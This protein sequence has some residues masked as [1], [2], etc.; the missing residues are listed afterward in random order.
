MNSERA[1]ILAPA[2][3]DGAVAASIMQQAGK[4]AVCCAD[5]ASLINELEVGAG[6]AIIVIEALEYTDQKPLTD[7]IAR[8][9]PWSDFPFIIL[10]HRV[11]TPD[12]TPMLTRLQA[13]VGNVIFL[14][15]PF[16]PT[17]LSNVVENALRGRRRQYEARD[18]LEDR[19]RLLTQLAEEKA[20]TQAALRGEQALSGLLITSVPAGIVAY[21][22]NLAVT[23]WN[24]VM[25][26]LLKLPAAEATGKPLP[27]LV[28]DGQASAIATGLKEALAGTPGPIEE[29]ELVTDRAG[30]LVLETQ[31][32]PLRGGDGEIVGGAAFF[33]D[34]TER[35]RIEEQLR[36]A[37][38]MET[39]GQLTGGVAHDFNNLLSAIQGNLELLRKR[40][41]DDAH[42][43]RYIDGALQGASRGASLTARLLA[44][45][46][47]QELQ[48]RPTNLARLLEETRALIERSVGPLVTLQMQLDSELP[49]ARV[50]PNQLEL[51]I[52]NLAVNSR[53][54]MPDGGILRIELSACDGAK[55]PSG[56]R[57]E[58]LCLTVADE[59]MGMDAATLKSAIEPFFSTK[60]LG[61]GTGL[62][63]SMVHGLA[64]Q[65]GGALQLRSEVGKGTTAELWLP[66]S[67]T[68][69]EHST[70]APQRAPT[71]PASTILV[72]DDDMLIAMNTVDLVE[73][74]GHVAIEANSGKRALEILSS[75]KHVDAMVT[76]YAM[77]GMTGVELAVKA[78]E[79]R[80]ELPI[81][82]ASGYAELPSGAGLKLPR[83][84]KPFLQSDLAA[85]LADLLINQR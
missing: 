45:A 11:G 55:G 75:G 10:T 40:L 34:I 44:F 28:G 9:P 50:D 61:K 83:L 36:Q 77:P 41:P 3:R 81:L 79:L 49:P 32:A 29:I 52:L 2:G 21:D 8:Q 25:E 71:A 46:R 64:I 6:V 67:R 62:G 73:D 66:V 4:S 60:E 82:L 35:R 78:R 24:P 15:R 70:A 26:D 69:V 85:K 5:A 33:R 72:V 22:H 38:K 31:H 18:Y 43:R 16:H 30:R 65:L 47:K 7:W 57:G 74:L 54:A 51:A 12:Q 59:G 17:N 19:E 23:I 48:P 1:L 14:D 20:R 58:F 42:M 63:L 56:L 27:N 37:Q 68:A 39:I 53:D 76:D 13:I 80:P 84:G